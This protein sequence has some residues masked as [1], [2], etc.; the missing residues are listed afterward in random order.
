MAA[1]RSERHNGA[2]GRCASSGIQLVRNDLDINARLELRRR[3]RTSATMHCTP[4][5][6]ALFRRC[7]GVSC[8]LLLYDA[9][10]TSHQESSASWNSYSK[11]SRLMSLR[12]HQSTRLRTMARSPSELLHRSSGQMPFSFQLSLSYTT[13][14]LL[15]VCARRAF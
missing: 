4:L 12:A 5:G 11:A 2:P 9:T 13:H 10:S 3:K 1:V 14:I 6:L 8:M 15:A 7:G